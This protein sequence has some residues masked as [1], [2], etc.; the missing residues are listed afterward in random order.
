MSNKRLNIM[1]PK[2]AVST[3]FLTL[4]LF[5]C[6]SGDQLLGRGEG[7]RTISIYNIHT[8]KTLTVVYK[9]DGKYVPSAMKRINHIMRDWRRNES[10]VMNKDLIDLM[11]EMHTQL[12]SRKPI[13]LISGYRSLKTNNKLRKTRGGQA[14]K[15]RHILGMAADVHF[16]DVPVRELRDSALIRQRGGVGYY[17]TSGLPFVHMD[18]GRVR[19]WP[20][21]ARPQLA[22]LFPNGRS[23]HVPR[24]GRPLTKADARKYGAAAKVAKMR[25]IQLA[26][27]QRRDGIAIAALTPPAQES[28]PKSNPVVEPKLASLNRDGLNEKIASLRPSTLEEPGQARIR[29]SITPK[30]KLSQKEQLA[31]YK[32]KLSPETNQ[33]GETEWWQG[34]TIASL[35]P[36]QTK[37]E[38][39]HQLVQLASID[40]NMPESWRSFAPRKKPEVIEANNVAYSPEFDEEHPEE[41][42]YRPFSLSPLMTDQPVAENEGLL[43]L[44]PPDYAKGSV[45]LKDNNSIASSRFRPGLQFA[46]LSLANQFVGN[47]IT[48]LTPPPPVKA[49]PSQRTYKKRKVQYKKKLYK[50]K[51]IKKKEVQS[52]SFFGLF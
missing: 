19:H 1:S 18:V 48:D 50:K 33:N 51:K 8:K 42:N 52:N 29:P 4:T 31:A 49:E 28:K 36:L 46:H 5:I 41:L 35:S 32:P 27:R 34:Q 15:S 3:F 23:R 10:R 37:L 43:K 13:H 24:D 21:L 2:K 38:E 6:L 40:T 26:R 39:E 30:E 25:R 17:P 20:R 11:W 47:A 9:K 12:G 16:P 44:S 7:A 22:S 14:R 45:L